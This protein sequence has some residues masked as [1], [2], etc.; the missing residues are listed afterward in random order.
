MEKVSR[1][2]IL[3]VMFLLALGSHELGGEARNVVNIPC[4]TVGDCFDPNKCICSYLKLCMCHQ[5]LKFGVEE[6]ATT[7]L[8]APKEMPGKH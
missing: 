5:E 7:Y 1:M 2:A 6:L 4:N 3:V 8:G